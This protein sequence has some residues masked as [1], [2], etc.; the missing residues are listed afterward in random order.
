MWRFC[1]SG[2]A[3]PH[4]PAVTLAGQNPA[5]GG[6]TGEV[7]AGQQSPRR[8]ATIPMTHTNE[9]KHPK[10]DVAGSNQPHRVFLPR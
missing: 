2:P 5:F 6:S 4:A 8:S 10:L 7:L 1:R 3:A 9:D